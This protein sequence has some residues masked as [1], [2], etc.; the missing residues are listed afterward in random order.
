VKAENE[1]SGMS[2]VLNISSELEH[3]LAAEAG[4]LG[5]SVSDY[6]LQLI[7]A[8]CELRPEIRNGSDLVHYWQQEQLIGGRSD[9]E[10]PSEHARALRAAAETRS[11]A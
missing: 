10:D 9:I 11:P 2:V 3:K 4:R 1:A 6:A 5:I 7:K 8:G